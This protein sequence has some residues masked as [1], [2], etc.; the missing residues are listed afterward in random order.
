L[1][2]DDVTPEIT[3]PRETRRRFFGLAGASLAGLVAGR[4]AVGE[5]AQAADGAPL[6]LGQTNLAETKT[7]L[8]TSNPIAGDG[9]FVVD[10]PNASYGVQG[11]AASVG[12]YGKGPIGVLGEGAVGGVFA[13]TDTAISLTPTGKSGPPTTESLKGDVTVDADGVL[14]FCIADGTPG[15]WIKLS[16]GG[17]RPLA[18]PQRAFGTLLLQGEDRTTQIAG[19]VPGV[20]PQA[21]GIVG[22]RTIFDMLGGGY[23]TLSPAGTPRPATSN[24]NWNGPAPVPGAALANAFTVGLGAGG[25]VSLFADATVAPGTAATKVL[26]DVTAYVL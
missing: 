7:A 2:D 26:L 24:V 11:T 16:H 3:P 6:T 14:W 8:H 23:V 15:T 12:V 13:G 21:V 5:T 18:S 25:G 10:A 1:S 19:V 20:P 22:N 4:Y 17:V 9:A